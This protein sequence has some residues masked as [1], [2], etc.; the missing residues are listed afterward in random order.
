MRKM[1]EDL[2][3]MFWDPNP[4]DFLGYVMDTKD[5]KELEARGL[6]FEV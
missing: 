4:G 3:N 6:A 5:M 2:S 1:T